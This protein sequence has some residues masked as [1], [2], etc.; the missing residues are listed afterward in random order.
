MQTPVPYL[1]NWINGKESGPERDAW[2]DKF[3]PHSGEL[4]SRFADSSENDVDRA[5]SAAG[6]AFSNWA[7]LTPVRRGQ[8]ASEIVDAMKRC[9]GELAECAA[10]ET[11]KLPR[12]AQNEVGAAIL[13]GEYFAGEGMRFYGRSLTS[14]VP[15]KYSHTVRQPCGIVGLIVP[16]NTPIAN[17]AWKVFPAIVCGNTV[18]L[19]ASEDA[20][21]TALLFARLATEAGVPKGVVNV[22]QGRGRVYR[23]GGK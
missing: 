8:I 2:L 10:R 22:V 4:L 9:R 14:G 19:K 12:D 6:G 16:A 13:Q 1:P 15:G 5:I 3:D 17:I 18:V 7:E 21:H 20:P 11:G 23:L